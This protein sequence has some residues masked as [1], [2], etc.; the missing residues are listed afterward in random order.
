MRGP[1]RERAQTFTLEAF[2]AA[3]LLLAAVAF[4]L[5]VV[6]ISSNT[7]S[8]ADSELGNQNA[9]LARGVLD[10]AVANGTLDRSL[11]YWN[12]TN[13]S[14]HRADE[15]PGDGGHYVARLP[16]HPD[17][18]AFGRALDSPFASRQV[19]YNVDLYYENAS[20]NGSV[21]HQPLVESGTPGDGAVRVVETVTL[22]DDDRLLAE[23]GSRENVTLGEVSDEQFYAPDASPDGPLYNVIRV[24]V[25]L[26]KP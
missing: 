13:E 16:Q 23:N 8:P 12:Q 21:G 24:E 3:I 11:R 4:G 1:E 10:A 22:Y 14:F 9:G 15:R 19:R 5:Q 17:A 2:V 7:A 6:S 20:G 26:W 25:V 18:P